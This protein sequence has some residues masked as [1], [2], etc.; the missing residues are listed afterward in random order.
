MGAHGPLVRKMDCVKN[1]L[2]TDKK[3]KN[4]VIEMIKKNDYIE[5]GGRTDKYG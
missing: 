3:E 5:S 2:R 1:G 4:V